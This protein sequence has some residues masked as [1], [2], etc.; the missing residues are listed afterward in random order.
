MDNEVKELN[1]RAH[2]LMQNEQ[3]KAAI[4]L[5]E[6]KPALVEQD[7]SLSWNLGW[8][9]FKLENWKTAQLHLS[10]AVSL[11]PTS[12]VSWWALGVAQMEDGMLEEAESNLKVS[13]SLSDSSLCRGT[14][15]LILMMRGK[16]AEAEQVHL[17]GIELKPDAP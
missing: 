8:A 9:Y 6:S 15:G 7:A 1:D 5:I 16:L 13:L 14:L 4:A 2:E 10:R 17:A 11:Q 3:W 12:G